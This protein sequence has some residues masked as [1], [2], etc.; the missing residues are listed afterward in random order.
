MTKKLS[1]VE[2]EAVVR[3]PRIAGARSGKLCIDCNLPIVRDC[4]EGRCFGCNQRF[5]RLEFIELEQLPEPVILK[6]A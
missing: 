1:A 2:V 4:I 3:P 6:A 5:I